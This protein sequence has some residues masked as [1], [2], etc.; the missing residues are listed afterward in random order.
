[1]VIGLGNTWTLFA[2]SFVGVLKIL[3]LFS[4]INC[5]VDAQPLSRAQYNEG[6]FYSLDG[7]CLYVAE[8]KPGFLQSC[9]LCPLVL[10]QEAPLF[11]C[12]VMTT[13]NFLE[14]PLFSLLKFLPSL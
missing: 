10:P 9:I 11:H 8:R 12:T 5:T 3:L 6:Q 4:K 14:C 2:L 13:L 1:M 7:T